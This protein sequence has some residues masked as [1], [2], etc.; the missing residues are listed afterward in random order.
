V[1]LS[2]AGL[3]D[4]RAR[5][6]G[7]SAGSEVLLSGALEDRP[8]ALAFTHDGRLLAVTPRQVELLRLDGGAVIVAGLPLPGAER[9]VRAPAALVSQDAGSSAAWVLTNRTDR[10]GLYDCEG[11]ALSLRA[12]ASA[13]PW[14]GSPSGVRFREGTDWL[15]GDVVGV[16]AGP[17]LTVLRGDRNLAV[18]PDGRLLGSGSDAPAEPSTRPVVGP[19]LAMLQPGL[20]FAST[21]RPPGAEDAL[22]VLEE[23]DG[24]YAEV[25]AIPVE[26]AICAL[27]A[28]PGRGGAMVVASVVTG[29][30]YELRR[31]RVEERR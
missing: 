26:G 28:R 14:P 19:T 9:P 25:R 23:G 16:G 22:L 17:F 27:A 5:A 15:E 13:L 6:A 31:V 12:E 3:W 29:E 8:L 18:S 10:A 7:P 4:A 20:L 1:V 11:D 24:G 21:P 2:L 30:G